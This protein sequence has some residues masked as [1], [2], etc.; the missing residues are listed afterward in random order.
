MKV[1]E[2]FWSVDRIPEDKTLER[3][4]KWSG[5]QRCSDLEKAAGIRWIRD[6]KNWSMQRRHIQRF[7]VAMMMIMLRS[8]IHHPNCSQHMITPN[9]SLEDNTV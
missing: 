7:L 5:F 3:L 8:V 1:F 9:D 6:R 4:P 2:R